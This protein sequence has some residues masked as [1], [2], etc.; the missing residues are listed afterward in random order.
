MSQSIKTPTI[1]PSYNQGVDEATY[2]FAC[3]IF[4]I[5]DN[6]EPSAKQLTEAFEKMKVRNVGEYSYECYTDSG[7]D[8]YFYF[9]VEA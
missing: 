4:G 8:D 3:L 5:Y 9:K 6:T 1:V 2:F 7:S